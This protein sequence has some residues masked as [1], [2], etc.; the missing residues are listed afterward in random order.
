MLPEPPPE[1]EEEIIE[2]NELAAEFY[3]FQMA[4]HDFTIIH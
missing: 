4:L 2:K 3:H 1:V